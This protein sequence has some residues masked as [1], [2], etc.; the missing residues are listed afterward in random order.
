MTEPVITL[1]QLYGG[2]RE[3]QQRLVDALS[4]LSAEEL[5]LGVGPQLRSIAMLASHIVSVRAG[6]LYFVLEVQDARLA[7][8]A[9][10]A[11]P[12]QPPRTAAEFVNGLETT[13]AVIEETLNQWTIA[14]LDDQVWDT[15]DDGERIPLTRQWVIWHLI[16]HDMHHG[17]EL[18][19][20]L[21]LNGLAG[22][23]I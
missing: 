19:F 4:P 7:P 18:S 23:E 12:D 15:N 17:G 20:A 11:G 21:G 13:W 2:W 10:W 5:N 14:N 3:Y 6:W 22:V 16:E 1:A 8:F 9:A